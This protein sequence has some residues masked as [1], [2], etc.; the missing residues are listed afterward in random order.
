MRILRVVV[1]LHFTI[2]ANTTAPMTWA[3][4]FGRSLP[5]IA[6]WFCSLYFNIFALHFNIFLTTQFIH[7]FL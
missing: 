6:A 4:E 2:E 1:V 3:L 5:T 7:I